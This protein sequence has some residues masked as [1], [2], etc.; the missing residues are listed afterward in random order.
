M[1]FVNE[2]EQ[3]ATPFQKKYDKYLGEVKDQAKREV[4]AHDI[5]QKEKID[6]ETPK[7]EQSMN[8]HEGFVK[9]YNERMTKKKVESVKEASKVQYN[10]EGKRFARPWDYA[11][12]TSIHDPIGNILR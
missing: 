6:F 2:F 9:A 11:G 3:K 4:L 8:P 12:Y 10:E 5:L 1:S 7:L